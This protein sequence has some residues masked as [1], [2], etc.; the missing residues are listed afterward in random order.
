MEAVLAKEFVGYVEHHRCRT[1][2]RRQGC[3]NGRHSEDGE[4]RTAREK[5]RTV[6]LML[7]HLSV[8]SVDPLGAGSLLRC[9]M[10]AAYTV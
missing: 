7:P 6:R 2:V 3:E 1:A 5:H 10:L 4:M 8:W 9:W